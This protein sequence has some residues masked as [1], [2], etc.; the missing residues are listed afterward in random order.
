[1]ANNR[2]K[3][4]DFRQRIFKMV[5]VGVVDDRI[6]QSY[7]VISTAML[8]INLCGAFAGTFDSVE[9]QH[10]LLL[11]QIEAVTVAFFAFDY[12]LLSCLG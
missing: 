11:K 2:Q 4:T 8:L 7:D 12:V 5:S 1:M 9:M 3:P 6:N 10:G